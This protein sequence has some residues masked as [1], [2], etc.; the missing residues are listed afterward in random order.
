MSV[1]KFPEVCRFCRYGRVVDYGEDGLKMVCGYTP[2]R[3]PVEPY[4]RCGRFSLDEDDIM[5]EV[6]NAYREVEDYIYS[7][8]GYKSEGGKIEV[9]ESVWIKL[10][11]VIY[12]SWNGADCQPYVLKMEI[13]V[14]FPSGVV[15]DICYVKAWSELDKCIYKALNWNLEESSVQSK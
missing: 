1:K 2:D 15:V 7:K 9:G 5:C 12:D 11:H 10:A 4:D 13:H 6:E 3:K 14:F 8:F